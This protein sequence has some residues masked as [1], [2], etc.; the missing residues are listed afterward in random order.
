LEENFGKLS[1]KAYDKPTKDISLTTFDNVLTEV[2]FVADEINN[3]VRNHNY[4]YLDISVAVTEDVKYT[5][6]IEEVFTKY[7][8]PFFI[9]SKKDVSGE[10]LISMVFSFLDMFVKVPNYSNIIIIC[11]KWNMIIS[12]FI[13]IF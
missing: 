1:I 7:Q 13:E 4:R 12:L 10:N 3:L 8:I 5:R 2:Y 11:F 6:L 9:D